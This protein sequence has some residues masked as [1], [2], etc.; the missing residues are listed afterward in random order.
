M[1]NQRI[2]AQDT[3]QAV[4]AQALSAV[5]LNER[6]SGFALLHEFGITD[7][8]DTEPAELTLLPIEA[9]NLRRQVAREASLS[10]YDDLD[11]APVARRAL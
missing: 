7:Y 9:D 10:R 2:T 1:S 4:Q 11:L 3:A 5:E 6:D 8:A